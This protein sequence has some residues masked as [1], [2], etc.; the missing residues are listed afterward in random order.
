MRVMLRGATSF[1]QDLSS[2]D[3][4]NVTKMTKMLD[5]TA[6]SIENYDKL[7]NS[8]SSQSLQN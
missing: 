6:I 3:V 4:S 8:W 5:K 2:W 7:L 1:N